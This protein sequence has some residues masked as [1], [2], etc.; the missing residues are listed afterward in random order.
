MSQAEVDAAVADRY[1]RIA[2]LYRSGERDTK[3]IA[4]EVGVSPRSVC[5]A[6]VKT[7]CRDLKVLTRPQV[8][9]QVMTLLEDGA[10]YVDVG[11]TFGLDPKWLSD[12][13]PGFGW[14]GHDSGIIAHALRNP[15][16]RRIHNEIRRMPLDEAERIIHGERKAS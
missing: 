8:T 14:S 3:V 16:V 4:A 2:E 9:P 7:G 10:S 5:R 1:R 13:L 11:E 15:E 12:N 6:L